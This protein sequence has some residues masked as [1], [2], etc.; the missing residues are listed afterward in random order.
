MK[1]EKC[2]E[3]Q[4]KGGCHDVDEFY[5]EPEPTQ[6]VNNLEKWKAFLTEQ[7]IEYDIQED[8]VGHLLFAESID[9]RLCF[10]DGSLYRG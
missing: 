2:G 6:E 4:F 9:L 8:A 1:C 7:G 10:K 5:R 3:E